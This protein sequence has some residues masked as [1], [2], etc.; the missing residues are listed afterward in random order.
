M[1][2][3]FYFKSIN[4]IGGVE[5]FFYYLSRLYKNM[6]VYYGEA[7]PTQVKR[8]AKN[9]EVHKWHGEHIKCKRFFGNYGLDILD[10]VDAEE[11]YFVIHCDYKKNKYCKPLIYPDFKYIAVSKLAGES[12]KEMTGLD[13][14]VIYNPI[15]LDIPKV[16]KKEG[17]NLISATRLSGEKGGWRIDY[18]SRL[19]DKV[20]VKYTWTIYT[21]KPKKLKSLSPNIVLKEPKLDLTK[22]IAESTYL[23]QL[24]DHEAF[25]LS[26]AEALILGTPVIITDLP[27]FNEIGCNETNSI[28]LD[29][30]MSNV[31]IDKILKGLP[32]FKYSPPKS[33]WG[34]YLDNNS[35]YNP[36]DK[37]KTTVKKR[38]IDIELNKKL[39]KN[40]EIEMTKERASFLEAKGY[41]E[42]CE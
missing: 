13:Y 17:L 31:D 36:K 21:N 16:D 28:K 42:I 32:P 6:V 30:L 20:G 29:L 3:V 8:L 4:A 39:E 12:F 35:N 38:Y 37:V 2:N 23:V 15:D 22:E 18:L 25:G 19:L 27:A 24:S 26:V 33:N 5:S 41:V 34:K 10:Y 11:K 9:I 7:D 1:E 40:E 14:E